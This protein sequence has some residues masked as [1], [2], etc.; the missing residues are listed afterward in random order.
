M[1]KIRILQRKEG[2]FDL[3]NNPSLL[4]SIFCQTELK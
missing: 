1:Q 2:L 3:S 4:F